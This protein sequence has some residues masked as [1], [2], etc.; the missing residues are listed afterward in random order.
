MKETKSSKTLTPKQVQ[1]KMEAACR[2]HG[3]VSFEEF[4]NQVVG[5]PEYSDV[6]YDELIS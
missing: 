5:N 6:S 4:V 3:M 2:A 1:A